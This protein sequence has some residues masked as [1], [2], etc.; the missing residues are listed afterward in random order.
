MSCQGTKGTAENVESPVK[1]APQTIVGACVILGLSEA[2]Q[3]MN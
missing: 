1:E 3:V 2:V